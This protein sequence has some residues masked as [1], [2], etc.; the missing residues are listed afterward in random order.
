M[1]PKSIPSGILIRIIVG[2]LSTVVLVMLFT[3]M[4]ASADSQ[5]WSYPTVFTEELA[6]FVQTPTFFTDT[7]GV[8]HAFWVASPAVDLPNAIYHCN[9]DG[10]GWSSPV[11][12]AV[13]PNGTITSF[14]IAEDRNENLYVFWSGW[15]GI[16]YTWAPSGCADLVQAWS[17]PDLIPTEQPF[18]APDVIVDGDGK[19]LLT[20]V[21]LTADR[22]YYFAYNPDGTADSKLSRVYFGSNSN[23][24]VNYPGIVTTPEGT[25]LISWIWIDLDSGTPRGGAYAY[26]VDHGESWSDQIPIIDPA[27]YSRFEE[28]GKAFGGMIGSLGGNLFKLEIGGIGLGGRYISFSQD[29]GI[30]WEPAFDLGTGT[31]EGYQG[32]GAAMDSAGVI[33]FLVQTQSGWQIVDRKNGQWLLPDVVV[34]GQTVATCCSTPGESTENGAIGVSEG[35]RLHVVFEEA[36]VRIWYTSKSLAS[37][38]VSPSDA[39]CPMQAQDASASVQVPGELSGEVKLGPG[40]TNFPVVAIQQEPH[41]QYSQNQWMPLMVGIVPT[42]TIIAIV[43]GASRRHRVKE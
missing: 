3:P 28:S 24:G 2:F 14:S 33:H 15:Q 26:S 18:S 40:I 37:P 35:N 4:A 5:P 30:T 17:M 6:G 43:I 23:I 13:S 41:Q 16:W 7:N 34:S 19:F 25:I 10:S 11:D 12:I 29:Q 1:L 39:T 32:V 42:M 20:F 8:L 21:P 9:W 36:D 27:R 38:Y 22:V 31:G